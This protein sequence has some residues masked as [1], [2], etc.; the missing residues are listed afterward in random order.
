V[1]KRQVYALWRMFSKQPVPAV[2]ENAKTPGVIGIVVFALLLAVVSAVVRIWFPIDRWVYLLG[3]IKVAFADVPRDLS[4]FI[5]GLVA[6]RRNWI[7]GFPT[8]AG[9]AWLG[10]G[11]VL[12]VFWYAFDLFLWKPMHLSDLQFGIMYPIWESLLC[13]SLAIGL[14]VLFREF[15]NHQGRLWAELAKSQYSVYIFHL[16]V[17]IFIQY[18]VLSFALPPLSKFILVTLVSIPA[19]FLICQWLRK[20][21]GL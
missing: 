10:V 15:F 9:L 14:T 11:V 6:Y 2:N 16:L 4:F 13:C 3:F 12:A 20:P 7:L 8:K 18:L 21:L 5:I 1:Y 17:V 19:T